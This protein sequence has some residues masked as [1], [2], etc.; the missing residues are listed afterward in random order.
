MSYKFHAPSEC[1]HQ[2][3]SALKQETERPQLYAG[4]AF[5]FEPS[6][7]DSAAP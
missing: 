2:S 6:S 7:G 4:G 1:P 3:A 5:F